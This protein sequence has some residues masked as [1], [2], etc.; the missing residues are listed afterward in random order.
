MRSM[1]WM[2]WLPVALALPVCGAQAVLAQQP[3]EDD[4]PLRTEI[5]LNGLF[6]DN[7][8]QAP[9][10]QP[11]EDVKGLQAE[12]RLE[13]SLGAT[14]AWKGYGRASYTDYDSGLDPSETLGL[15]IQGG[16]RVHRL[17]L[18]AEYAN[19][20]PSID[21][22][23]FDQADVGRLT[24]TYDFRPVDDW[25]FSGLGTLEQQRYAH[26]AGRDN[27]FWS[28]GAAVRFRGFG[29]GFSPEAGWAT[30]NRD[31]DTANESYDQD[32][33][34]VRVISE[35][36]DALYLALRYRVRQRDYTVGDPLASN[37]GRSDD[38]PQWSVT[39]AYRT[40]EHLSW[41]LY[42]ARESSSSSRPGI[43]FTTQLLVVGAGWRF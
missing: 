40:G 25:Q 13:G 18:Y 5:R 9:D 26:A 10:G 28:A 43:D 41:N 38:R 35:P 21:L 20:R 1:K 37:F 2:K 32:E 29:P 8:F 36:A 7:L 23:V 19:D 14:A 3:A 17:D 33:W 22:D 4:S 24:A 16:S 11:Q 39:G 34:W 15:G 6:F 42:W 27:Q 12:G 31:V 30:G